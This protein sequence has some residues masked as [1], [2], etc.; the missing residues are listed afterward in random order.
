MF[1]NKEIKE[2]YLQYREENQGKV[3]VED[4]ALYFN[5]IYSEEKKNDLDIA[6]FSIEEISTLYKV[7]RYSTILMG[8]VS[9]L[10]SEYVDWI[11]QE[12]MLSVSF[13]PYK[14]LKK[15]D[16]ARIYKNKLENPIVGKKYIYLFI[17]LLD[18]PRDKFIALAMFEGISGPF[19]CEIQLAKMEHI[20]Q[21][22]FTMD[23]Y[24]YNEEDQPVYNRT[25]PISR[26]LLK[27]ALLADSEYDYKMAKGSR[28]LEGNGIVKYTKRAKEESSYKIRGI[29]LRKRIKKMFLES[30]IIANPNDKDFRLSGLIS[31]IKQLS[32]DEGMTV[33]EATYLPE[34]EQYLRDFGYEIN[35]NSFRSK[36]KEYLN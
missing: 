31:K 21:E 2:K 7:K 27:Y 30:E 1:Y 22:E 18:N 12:D 33:Y 35:I 3:K 34:S 14:A 29:E 17:D 15:S 16:F 11:I 10:L 28:V 32:I 36:M 25:V 20:N 26:E 4:I 23:L 19:F 13:N 6:Q 9:E 5:E 8:K 24:Q